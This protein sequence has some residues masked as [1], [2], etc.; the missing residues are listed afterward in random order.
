MKDDKSIAAGLRENL[1][2]LDR[3]K[4][5]KDR[6]YDRKRRALVNALEAFG[7]MAQSARGTGGGRIAI[8]EANGEISTLRDLIREY[9]KQDGE[10]FDKFAVRTFGMARY[11]GLASKYSESS[12]ASTL[13]KMARLGMGIKRL[14]PGNSGKASKYQRI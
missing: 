12:I 14:A 2:E 9:L 10:P 1:A 3:D 11:P 5:E 4:A 13:Q 6:D 7:E 8:T